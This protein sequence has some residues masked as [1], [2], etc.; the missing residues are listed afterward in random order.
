MK[1]MKLRKINP[2][3]IIL[4]VFA[5]ILLFTLAAEKSQGETITV[6]DDGGG[7]L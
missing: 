2:T 1:T 4:V 3:E 7:A 6:D 5:C